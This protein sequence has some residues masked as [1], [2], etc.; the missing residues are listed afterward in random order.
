MSNNP[1]GTFLQYSI[2]LASPGDV[3]KER[4]YVEDVIAELNRTI[5]KSRSVFLQSRRWEMDTF[6]QGGSDAQTIINSQIADM[7]KCRLFIGIM[8]NR[9]GSRT[10]RALSGTVEEY[11]RAIKSNKRHQAPDVWF[12]F[13]EPKLIHPSND[14]LHQLGRVNDFKT[15]VQS[16]GLVSSYK[17]PQEFKEMVRKHLMLW[18]ESIANSTNDR[19]ATSYRLNPYKLYYFRQTRKLSFT[20]LARHSGIDRSTLRRLENKNPGASQFTVDSFPAIDSATLTALERALD[21]HGKLVG[22]QS[23]DFLSQYI[24]FY[25]TYKKIVNTGKHLKRDVRQAELRFK[26]RAVVFDFGGTLTQ[27][28]GKY[29]TWEKL[30]RKAGYSV[31]MCSELHRRYQSGELS[32]QQWCDETCAAFRAKKLSE[33]NIRQIAQQVHLIPGVAGT[34]R[35]LR[36]RG[37]KLYVVS[38]SL[39]PIIYASLGELYREFEEIRANDVTFDSNGIISRIGSTPYDFRG[40]A[41]FL[42][43]V[44]RELNISPLDVLFVGNSCNDVFAS[45]AGVRTLCVNPRFTDPDKPE[46]WTYAIREMTN[47][48]QIM[49]HVY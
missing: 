15:R 32:H 18:L 22:G 6:P 8:W 46:H 5:A 24:L 20:Q 34:I 43:R 1:S 47:L 36:K 4:R 3:R 10:P 26:T 21:C 14:Q 29:T 17:T 45:E 44:V 9:L 49:E 42:K 25:D 19:A 41:T 39:K 37:M 13:R 23:D 12:Y 11:E 35:D 7:A 40:K 28:R 33:Y 27:P 31:N 38:G 16:E 30:W 2:F 48:T